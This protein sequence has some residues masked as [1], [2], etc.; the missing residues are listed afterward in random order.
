MPELGTYGS[1]RGAPSDRRPY[2]D[3]ARRPV[4]APGRPATEK[5]SRPQRELIFYCLQSI[6][7]VGERGPTAVR[8]HTARADGIKRDRSVTC[9]IPQLLKYQPAC[10]PFAGQEYGAIRGSQERGFMRFG[11][12]EFTRGRDELDLAA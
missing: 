3:P 1:V 12:S 11:R 8:S 7:A 10:L 4:H 6:A 2:R 9:G 5:R